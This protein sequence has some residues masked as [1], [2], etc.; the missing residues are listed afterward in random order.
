[1][2]AAKYAG[3]PD[4][5]TAQDVYET[6]DTFTS[7]HQDGNSSEEEGPV[8][9]RGSG[10]R[11]RGAAGEVVPSREE[12][13]SS[14][15]MSAEAAGKKF[16]NAE[17]RQHRA[18][19]TYAYPP[20]P[21]SDDDAS[22]SRPP[23]LSQRLRALQQEV[24][25]L[26]AELSD[27]SNPL[28]REN[29]EMVDPGVLMK[30]LVDVRGRLEKVSKTKDGR[31][32]LVERLLEAKEETSTPSALAVQDKAPAQTK[33]PDMAEIDR[34]V[35]ELENLVGSSGTTL[36]ESSPLPPPLLPLVT[37]LS[38]QLTILTQPRHIDSI[39][40]RLKLLLSDLER[41]SHAS[42]QS[43]RQ[44][45][46]PQ[47]AALPSPLQESL[48][49]V[50][51]RLAPILPHI[52][53]IL[54]RLRTLSALH[55]SASTFNETLEGMEEEQRRVRA[56]LEELEKAVEAVEKSLEDNS[57]VTATNVSGLEVRVEDLGKRM[58]KLR[59]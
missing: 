33:T 31:G 55:T 18:R 26:E 46:P 15:L 24:A 59:S 44:S 27:P 6:P 34:R 42:S 35:G 32:K 3:L 28:L 17:R 57:R 7:S 11:G 25:S 56:V 37:R 30:G 54:T 48:Q 8:P 45:Q 12:L 20:S 53:H 49:P 10:F 39:S 19:L 16:R 43:R 22:P 51:T 40:R 38:N 13:D 23:P 29:G 21:T 47:P 14:P 50:L 52:P 1:M 58:E 5:D 9:P 41:A 4:I 2:S 36:D